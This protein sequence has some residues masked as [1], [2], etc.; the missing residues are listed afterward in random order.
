MLNPV[1]EFI[2]NQK[3]KQKEMMLFLKDYFISYSGITSKLSYKIPFFYGKKWICYLNPMKDGTVDLCFCRGNQLSNK[4]GMLQMK[5][6]K[7]IASMNLNE[8]EKIPFEGIKSI[9]KEA[10][11]LDQMI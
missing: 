6:R 3:E 7:M 2:F 11:I 1:D 5:G 9:F 8:L 10:L 4:E